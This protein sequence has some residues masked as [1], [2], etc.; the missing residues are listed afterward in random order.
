MKLF[1]RAILILAAT[2][3]LIACSHAT[4][5][6][7]TEDE[8]PQTEGSTTTEQEAP[9]STNPI[10]S[11]AT[12]PVTQTMR[13][14]MIGNSLTDQIRYR[15]FQKLAESRSFTQLW[16]RHMIP[17]APLEWIWEHPTDGIHDNQNWEY[18]GYDFT[19]A[20]STME[21]DA[22]TLQPFVRPLESDIEH[23]EKFMDIT[24]S[25]SSTCVFYIHAQ[26]PQSQMAEWWESGAFDFS[27]AWGDTYG[28]KE[29][30]VTASASFY[31]KLLEGLRQSRGDYSICLIPNGWVLAELDQRIRA[32][33]ITGYSSILGFWE[34]AVHLT[35]AGS[36]LVACT[37]FSVIYQQDPRG[38]PVPE[39]YGSIDPLL[40][41]HIQ[42]AVWKVVTSMKSETGIQSA[43]TA[44]SNPPPASIIASAISRS[45]VQARYC[46]E[47]P[48]IDG[49][50]EESIWTV[51]R[52]L[53]KVVSGNAGMVPGF[54]LRWDSDKLYVGIK[55][56]DWSLVA[57]SVDLYIGDG[58]NRF[59]VHKEYGSDDISLSKNGTSISAAAIESA[60]K[61]I[62]D[63]PGWSTEIAI[64][65]SAL[66]ISAAD[67]TLFEFD[68]ACNG[69]NADENGPC[70]LSWKAMQNMEDHPEQWGCAA[71]VG[72]NH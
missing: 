40:V 64:P 69:L 30:D 48:V 3:T 68:L 51:E 45:D 61:A 25:K 5:D 27:K 33:S 24:K 43:Y 4:P 2:A 41:Y 54:A 12:R 1:T 65:W 70:R 59:T 62:P 8:T 10:I 66:G 22:V 44:P 6:S 14:Y 34:D 50:M 17:G 13:I 53:V 15:G 23:C 39:E 37:F 38:L 63:Y 28:D 32:G 19:N 36:Y 46:D 47:P 9:P 55:I 20:L 58:T 16:A 49:N 56:K 52:F 29:Y 26:W 60:D 72:R 57:E 31:L 7:I 42:D 35:N 21:W 18:E 67:N 71:L 11:S